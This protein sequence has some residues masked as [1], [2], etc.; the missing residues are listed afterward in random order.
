MGGS[1]RQGV[2]IDSNCTVCHDSLVQLRTITRADITAIVGCY[3]CPPYGRMVLLETL[4][5]SPLP[6]LL[7]TIMKVS[8]ACCCIKDGEEVQL[9]STDAI[10]RDR[11]GTFE[12]IIC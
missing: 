7:I 8:G 5:K 10:S 9:L 12:Y 11:K 3:Y 1:S 2:H 4:K 6:I